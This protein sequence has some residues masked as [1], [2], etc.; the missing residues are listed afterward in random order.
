MIEESVYLYAD[1]LK[2]EGILTYNEDA[3]PSSAILLCA[4]HPN[5]GGDMDN[6][7]ITSIARVSADMGFLSLRFNYR[8]VGN[9]ESHE[10]DIVQRFH[11]WEESLHGRNLMDAVTDTQAA[12]D[13]LLSQ[14][15]VHD[16]IFVA[17]Y[18][19][20]ALVGMKI[21]TESSRVLAFAFISTPFG[22]YNLDFLSHCNKEKLFIYSQN[23]FATTVE[24]TVNGFIKISPPKIL[25]LIENSD[26][27]YRNQEDKV[28]QKV[29]SFFSHIKVHERK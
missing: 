5:L 9:S 13:F 8:G 26:H 24:E 19:F 3:L 18:S 6:N 15:A 28:S 22:R 4:P 1:T 12:L 21:G 10:K 14:I 2:L 16:R 29:C 27:F 23:D 7:V 25:E 20:G 11:Y 17:G